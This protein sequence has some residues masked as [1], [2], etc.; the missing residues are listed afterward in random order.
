[1]VASCRSGEAAA[2]QGH[3]GRSKAKARRR[4]SGTR[5]AGWLGGLASR[6]AVRAAGS[7]K[8]N[9]R[10]QGQEGHDAKLWRHHLGHAAEHG[11]ARTAGR[12]N[13][14]GMYVSGNHLKGL[15]RVSGLRS[16]GVMLMATVGFVASMVMR[17]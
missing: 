5:R 14:A 2:L 17:R 9:V 8:G 3:R 4:V 11:S 7:H 6:R 16:A 1:M 13:A 10:H 12:A 15:C